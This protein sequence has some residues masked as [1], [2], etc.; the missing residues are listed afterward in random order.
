MQN[1]D[2][3]DAVK[4]LEQRVKTLEEQNQ[5]LR[6]EVVRLWD[7]INSRKDQI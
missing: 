1:H 4:E 2:K 6:D 5:W 7:A 3:P